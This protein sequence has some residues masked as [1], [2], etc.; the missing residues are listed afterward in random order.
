MTS[1]RERSDLAPREPQR[2]QARPALAAIAAHQRDVLAGRQ[3]CR[4]EA[5]ALLGGRDRKGN[6]ARERL[7]GKRWRPTGACAVGH[8][9]L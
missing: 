6:Q 9:A 7:R 4:S 2:N 3:P 8:A 1:L 5:A